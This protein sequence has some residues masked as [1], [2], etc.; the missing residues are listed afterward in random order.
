MADGRW[1]MTEDEL[2]SVASGFNLRRLDELPNYRKHKQIDNRDGRYDRIGRLAADVG[3]GTEI[4]STEASVRCAF[5]GADGLEAGRIGF[6]EGYGYN[7]LLCSKCGGSTD[8]VYKDEI[9]KYF[10]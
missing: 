10:K 3:L 6:G 8:L 2:N 1:V 5:C 7:S 9:G 4:S